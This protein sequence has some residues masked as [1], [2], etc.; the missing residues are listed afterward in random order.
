MFVSQ[1]RFQ[2]LED[3]AEALRSCNVIL[4]IKLD[5]LTKE[6]AVLQDSY[7]ALEAFKHS[8][9]LEELEDK[10]EDI[11]LLKEL[12]TGQRL[13]LYRYLTARAYKL[14]KDALREAALWTRN[15]LLKITKGQKNIISYDREPVRSKVSAHLPD[16]YNDTVS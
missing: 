4:E 12:T 13:A 9:T 16:V 15:D 7:I 8:T 2:R 14:N 1:K 6:K 3:K 5:I 11:E 10:P